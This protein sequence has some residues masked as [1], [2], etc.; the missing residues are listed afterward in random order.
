M[1]EPTPPRFWVMIGDSPAGPLTAAEVHDRL[2]R[3]ALARTAK[4]CAV[5]SGEWLPLAR[6]P[7]FVPPAD[8]TGESGTVAPE[9]PARTPNVE[10]PEKNPADESRPLV[11]TAIAAAPRSSGTL[12][13][14]AGF[15][16]S[17]LVVAGAIWLFVTWAREPSASPPREPLRQ[18]PIG[19]PGKSG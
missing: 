18:A 2:A 1:P 15:V 19:P 7:G 12:G 11:P 13:V 17:L 9:A 4:A 3:G 6:H 16:V 14:V 10:R 8:A 5:G